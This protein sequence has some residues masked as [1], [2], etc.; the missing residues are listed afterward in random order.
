MDKRRKDLKEYLEFLSEIKN[1][2]PNTI[3]AYRQDIEQ[4]IN[5]FEENGVPLSRDNIKDFLSDI[6]M[7]TRNKSTLSRKIYAV[8]SFFQFLLNNGRIDKNPFDVISVPKIE[9]KLPKILT[10]NEMAGFLDKLPEGSILEIRN[11]AIFELLYASGLRVSELTNLKKENINFR[12]RLIRVFGK[13]KKVRIV[14]FNETAGSIIKKYLIISEKKYKILPEYIFLN[15]RGEK[16]SDRGIEKILK[17][18]FKEIC[19]TNKNIYPHLFRHS[20]ATHLLQRGVNLR[21][22][23]ELLGHSNLSTTEKYTVLNYSD[24]L[25]SYNKFHPRVEKEKE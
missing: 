15:F 19:E 20:F 4:F 22:I 24:L 6:Y 16:I 11:K 14:P 23:Q 7:N 8:R 5:W 25:K 12:E 3:K 21:V 17:K 9:K 1:F 13:G 10:E 2:S 18:T